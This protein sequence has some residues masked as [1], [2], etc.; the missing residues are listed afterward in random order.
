M[1]QVHYTSFG[2]QLHNK[3]YSKVFAECQILVAQQIGFQ[4]ARC[5]AYNIAV[6]HWTLLLS[7]N[8]HL[9]CSC[10][11]FLFSCCP[12]WF[13]LGA[14]WPALDSLPLVADRAHSLIVWWTEPSPA[15]TSMQSAFQFHLIRRKCRT[16]PAICR[17]RCKQSFWKLWPWAHIIYYQQ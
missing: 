2:N 3:P 17:K 15:L 5:N 9:I 16:P 13:A 4:S 8:V 7:V 14:A 11:L 1:A 10:F 12:E 6:L